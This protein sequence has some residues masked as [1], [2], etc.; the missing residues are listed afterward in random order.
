M[1]AIVLCLFLTS[2]DM[3]AEAIEG[4]QKIV[5]SYRCIL[6]I[7][8]LP[9]NPKHMM[10]GIV[11]GFFQVFMTMGTYSVLASL[12]LHAQTVLEV[13]MNF[14]AMQFLTE[15]DETLMQIKLVKVR[16]TRVHFSFLVEHQ[17]EKQ[18]TLQVRGLSSNIQIDTLT[19]V[20]INTLTVIAIVSCQMINT[21]SGEA[22]DPPVHENWV[23]HWFV[24]ICAMAA[25]SATLLVGSKVFGAWAVSVTLFLGWYLTYLVD[26]FYRYANDGQWPFLWNPFFS[27]L[28]YVMPF[29]NIPLVISSAFD[30][31]MFLKCPWRL[32]SIFMMLFIATPLW[33]DQLMRYGSG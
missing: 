25:N 6:G 15:V 2:I 7:Y 18:G 33:M 17:V 5:F 4:C 3:V 13:F 14:L 23:L 21:V 8:E 12:L 22:H 24:I 28:V 1:G 19:L 20:I 32:P 9:H 11:L 16:A 30:A 10:V 29:T 31:Q 27:I 26:I